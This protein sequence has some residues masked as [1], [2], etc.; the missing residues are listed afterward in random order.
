[1]DFWLWLGYHFWGIGAFTKIFIGALVID[2]ILN[3]VTGSFVNVAGDVI[4]GGILLA[5][6][7]PVLPILITFIT[8]SIVGIT[9]GGLIQ[10]PGLILNIIGLVLF[11]P[12]L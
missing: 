5:L 3:L 12:V 1:M 8:L 7:A 9:T 4:L 6:G 2:I 11:L 10:I